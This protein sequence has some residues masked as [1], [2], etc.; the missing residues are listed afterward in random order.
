MG[1][2]DRFG[3]EYVSDQALKAQEQLDI[4]HEAMS[5]IDAQ[6]LGSLLEVKREA[7]R[8]YAKMYGALSRLRAEF[9]CCCAKEWAP[10]ATALGAGQRSP[11][12]STLGAGERA[13]FSSNSEL[14]SN[15]APPPPPRGAPPEEQ[16]SPSNLHDA[17]LDIEPTTEL[18]ARVL[19]AQCSAVGTGCY[20]ETHVAALS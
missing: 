1:E 15:V 6:I 10:P 16:A 9:F 18:H 4:W 7:W 8:V 5:N 11:T 3:V 19:L 14:A 12:S 17:D 13:C 20:T 2:T